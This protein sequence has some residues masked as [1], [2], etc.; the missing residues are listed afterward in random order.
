MDDLAVII[1][2]ICAMDDRAYTGLTLNDH[3]NG[4]YPLSNDAMVLWLV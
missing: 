4:G 1:N 2:I 3:V